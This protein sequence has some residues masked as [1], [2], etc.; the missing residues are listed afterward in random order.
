MQKKLIALAV[1]SLAAAP[2]LAQ[3]NVTV[4]GVADVT[5]ENVRATGATAT[6]A[7][8]ENRQRVTANSS[9]LG[10]RGTEDLGN[11]LAAIFQFETGVAADGSGAAGPFTSTRD[12]FVGLKGG[13][14]TI[15]LGNN[16]NPYRRLGAAFDFNPGATGVPFNGAI[17]GQFGGGPINTGLT[18]LDDRLPNSVAY[19]SPNLAGFQAQAI[20]GANEG[21]TNAANPRS[22]H[23][24][25]LGLNYGNGPLYVGYTFERR[26]DQANIS[27]AFGPAVDNKLTGNRVGA[28]YQFM[29]TTTVGVLWDRAKLEDAAA[30]AKRDAWGVQLEHLMGANQFVVQYSQT[31]DL[32]G[33]VCNPPADCGE[34]AAKM[35]SVAWNYNLSK[36]TMIKTYY[37]SIRNERDAAYDFYTA[38]TVGRDRKSVV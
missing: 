16:S 17:V 7:S 26:N 28:K 3:T 31:R 18:G 25:G 19:D 29:G 6:G 13:F 38:P 23:T 32:K 12:T 36:R 33:S 22:D 27:A 4:Y 24:Y 35:W 15:K 1:A 37:A 2:A 34:S 11:G 8:L 14:G 20:Y 21:R 30:D 10:F 9:L 5:L